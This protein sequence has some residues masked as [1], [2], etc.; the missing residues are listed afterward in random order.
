MTFPRLH[1]TP[2]LPAAHAAKRPERKQRS[3]TSHREVPP[4][5]GKTL[6]T[7]AQF[8]DHRTVALNVAIHEV[9]Q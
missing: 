6:L 9:V 7:N 3:G 1:T 2:S 4:L 8:L 5:Y